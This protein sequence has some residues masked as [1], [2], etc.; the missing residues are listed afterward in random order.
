MWLAEFRY[1]KNGEAKVAKLDERIDV[2]L[3]VLRQK[4][5]NGGGNKI[6]S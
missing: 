1:Y 5:N 4:L 6:C 3:S 2:D